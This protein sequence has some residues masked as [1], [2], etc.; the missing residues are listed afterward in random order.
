MNR[1]STRLLTVVVASLLTVGVVAGISAA[2]SGRSSTVFYACKA[3]NGAITKTTT[4]SSLNCGRGK[5]VV[6]WNA[7]G[8]AGAQGAQ[9]APG[10]RGP[11][12]PPGP[13]AP[14]NTDLYDSMTI[15][16]NYQ[17]SYAYIATQSNDF[18]NDI[19][20]SNDGSNL[21]NAIVSM[22]NF[23]DAASSM[24]LAITFT[25][26][27][28]NEANEPG[29]D[30]Q[31]GTVIASKTVTVSPPGTPTGCNP[32]WTPGCVD[33]FNV[34]FNFGSVALPN[35][36]VYGISYDNSVVDTGLNVNL[37]YESSSVP[38]AGADTF[39]GYLFVGASNDSNDAGG[40]TGEITCQSV[41]TT[42]A[43]YSTAT[44]NT[45]ICG[46][47]ASPVAPG[48]LVPAVELTTS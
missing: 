47:D 8:P 22:G 44:N 21:K 13:A 48:L 41:T 5:S 20:L 26:Y 43:Q 30:I 24:P 28:P 29:N 12:G 37:S 15:A 10:A 39:P 11:V 23:G 38:S 6:T 31:P 33:N 25:I 9:G 3:R 34:T 32:T 27:N 42:F 14:G 4:S 18:G 16:N 45:G 36:V 17:W 35:Q 40:A 19:T 7:E 2:T 1:L 46:L